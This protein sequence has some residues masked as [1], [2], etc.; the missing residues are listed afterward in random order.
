MHI[1]IGLV[2]GCALL[3]FWLV[4]HWFARVLVFL[5]MIFLFGFIVVGIASDGH[6]AS[7]IGFAVS[8][9]G[10][11]LAWPISSIP[12]WYHARDRT[13]AAVSAEKHRTQQSQ[14]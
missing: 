1:L 10:V 2:L 3:Y 12:I 11:V 5:P 8:I 7:S 13:S 4:G 6:A 14:R 9:T